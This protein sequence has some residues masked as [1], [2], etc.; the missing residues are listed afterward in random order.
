MCRPGQRVGRLPPQAGQRVGGHQGSPPQAQRWTRDR[1]ALDGTGTV[2]RPSD[3]RSRA[4]RG[5]PPTHK[6]AKARTHHAPASAS[7]RRRTNPRL[8]GHPAAVPSSSVPPANT[9]VG[10]ATA[11]AAPWKSHPP[12]PV[13][14]HDLSVA[15]PPRVE[16]PP[17]EAMKCP[18]RSE[19]HHANLAIDR[20]D[21]QRSR[22]EGRTAPRVTAATAA[23]AP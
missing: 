1:S 2:R 13:R 16:R 20:G 6:T 17:V 7:F 12:R 15:L 5:P 9:T 23:P 18:V 10:T 4:R 22:P 11:T 8:A 3:R 19:H 21:L 14:K